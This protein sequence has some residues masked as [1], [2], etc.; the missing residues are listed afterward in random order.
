M[1]HF[2]IDLH[3]T[4]LTNDLNGTSPC[5]AAG[6]LYKEPRDCIHDLLG[7]LGTNTP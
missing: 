1:E 7:G 3:R 5:V 2:V 4:I 6:A